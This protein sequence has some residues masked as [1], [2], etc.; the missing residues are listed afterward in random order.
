MSQE[1]YDQGYEDGRR[2]QAEFIAS[3]KRTYE[4][5]RADLAQKQD[6]VTRLRSIIHRPVV[7]GVDVPF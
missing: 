7:G 3:W 6:E 2:S 4:E 1:D 5:A